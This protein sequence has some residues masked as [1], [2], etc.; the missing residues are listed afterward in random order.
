VSGLFLEL[1]LSV[2]PFIRPDGHLL[3][4]CEGEGTKLRNFKTR[5]RGIFRNTAAN[6]KAQSLA[7]AA[8]WDFA[9]QQ[10]QDVVSGLFL[11]Q[12][13]LSGSSESNREI[14]LPLSC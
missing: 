6:A 8:G 13:E 9:P 4:R 11:S 1:H 7:H 14:F 12:I 2:N 10:K 5:T 3:P